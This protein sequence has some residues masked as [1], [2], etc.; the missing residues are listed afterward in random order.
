MASRATRTP[1]ASRARRMSTVR[2]RRA[3]R[4]DAARIAEMANALNRYHEMDAVFSAAAV[5][6]DG[7][8]PRAAFRT[9]LAELDGEAVG[10]A[11]YHA[12]YNSD[13]AQRGLWLVDL[14]VEEV[15]RSHGIGRRL[16]AALAREALARGAASLWWGVDS[17]NGGARRM[18]AALG[19]HDY[20]YR[21]LELARS[22]LERLAREAGDG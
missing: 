22:D 19:A 4:R 3:S 10:Y 20:D 17:G 8:G 6:R 9:L 11:M 14:Y 15:A 18:Y 7:F 12:C 16:M 21:I 1:R 13:V 2:I 5:A